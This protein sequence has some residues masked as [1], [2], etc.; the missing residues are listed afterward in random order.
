MSFST[1]TV[2]TSLINFPFPMT[3]GFGETITFALSTKK[4][5]QKNK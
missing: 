5:W 3:E 2:D 1:D 4:L